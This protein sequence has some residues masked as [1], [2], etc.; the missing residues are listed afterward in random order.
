VQ[1][2]RYETSNHYDVGGEA[3][4]YTTPTTHPLIA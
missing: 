3:L 4:L 2:L 1:A